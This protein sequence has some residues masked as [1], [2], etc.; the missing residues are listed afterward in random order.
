MKKSKLVLRWPFPLCFVLRSF[1]NHLLWFLALFRLIWF[2]WGWVWK[3]MCQYKCS[4]FVKFTQIKGK[5][6]HKL[7][8]PL[9]QIHITAKQTEKCDLFPLPVDLWWRVYMWLITHDY[10][11][12]KHNCPLILKTETCHFQNKIWIICVK[13]SLQGCGHDDII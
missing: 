13:Y 1:R 7:E 10:E 6:L 12:H 9:V 3:E 8:N 4:L 5:A 2:L 11:R